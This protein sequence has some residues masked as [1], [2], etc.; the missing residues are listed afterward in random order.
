MTYGNTIAALAD[1]TRRAIVERLSTRP[2]SVSELAKGFPIS[3][4]AVS[5]HLKVLSDAGVLVV[6]PHGARRVYQLDPNAVADL[7]QWLDQLWDDALNAFAAEAG[8]IAKG[9]DN[10]A[11]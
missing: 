1:P 5:Q 8:R 6:H 7:R 11:P 3:R 9:T 2:Q 10:D 4:P